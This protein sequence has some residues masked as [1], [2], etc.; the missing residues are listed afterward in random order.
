[1]TSILVFIFLAFTGIRAYIQLA[2]FAGLSLLFSCVIA[3]VVLPLLLNRDHRILELKIIQP[4]W[5]IPPGGLLILLPI[6]FFCG[7]IL[8]KNA[9]FSLESLDGTPDKIR[10]EEQDFNRAWRSSGLKTAVIA[11]VGKNSD[12]ALCRLRQVVGPLS[13]DGISAVM[14]PVPPQSEQILNRT[15]WRTP[16]TMNRITRLEEQ[17][18]SACKKFRLPEKF[19]QPFFENLRK[20]I[21]SD[22]LTLPPMLESVMKKMVKT[23]GEK[24][25][26]VAL[27]PD[28]IN[29]A[30]AVRLILK[31]RNDEHYAL[32]SKEG[33]KQMVREDLGGRFL[34]IL[35]LSIL[36]ALLLAYLFFRKISDVLLAVTPVLV[37]FCGLFIL[38]ALTGFKAT[39]A[40]A[41]AL[42]L[43][44]GLA[45]DYGIYA[46]SQLRHPEEI[47]VR[48]SVLLSAATTVAGAGALI[49]SN[50]PALFGTGC[51]LAVGIILACLS[52][53]YLVPMLKRKWKKE[54]LLLVALFVIPLNGCTSGIPFEEYPEA[55]ILKRKMKIYP[56]MPFQLQANAVLEMLNRKYTFLLAAE[57]NPGTG[58]I[59]AAGISGA[60]TLLFRIN[61]LDCTAGSGMPENAGKLLSAFQKD[62]CRIFLLK[63]Q[64]PLAVKRKTEYIALSLDNGVKWGLH[65]D[66]IIRQSGSFPVRKW[67][68]EYRDSGRTVWYCNYRRNYTV[69][70]KIIRLAEKGKR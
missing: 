19:F 66:K 14:P 1:A 20:A 30:R 9:D 12:D 17:T 8:L 54:Q 42:I 4:E 38:G 64:T 44:T 34:W 47:S 49:F 33:F 21:S 23:H 58:E 69:R 56:E 70:L 45:I 52:G 46:V 10:E 28:T 16:E 61:G 27:L 7:K 15:Q 3:L 11:A 43:L 26:A 37:S 41:F 35:P 18:R 40:A 39:P 2:A 68:A 63:D 29:N 67:M 5:K 50:H 59:K 24:A 25:T 13:S 60:G 31:K 6:L 48:S 62:L 36:F 53:L 51:V 65:P 32:L 57:L 55:Q 22:D